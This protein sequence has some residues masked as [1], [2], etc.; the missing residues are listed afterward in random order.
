MY[1]SCRI[2]VQLQNRAFFINRPKSLGPAPEARTQL[3]SWQHFTMFGARQEAIARACVKMP[4]ELGQTI[5]GETLELSS[6]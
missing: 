5:E 2:E 1:N 4:L 6:S 3:V